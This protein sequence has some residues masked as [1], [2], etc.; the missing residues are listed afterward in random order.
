MAPQ[1]THPLG[2]RPTVFLVLCHQFA[3][4]FQ[5]YSRVLGWTELAASHDGL[6]ETHQKCDAGW[7][8]GEVLLDLGTEIIL[9]HVGQV[10]GQPGK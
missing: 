2:P 6:F 4:D 7:A 1:A 5:R 3:P 9:Q 10:I 8:I